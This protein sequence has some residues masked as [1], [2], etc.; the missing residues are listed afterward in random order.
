M[1][2]QPPPA[3]ER[4]QRQE[5]VIRLHGY[6]ILMDVGVRPHTHVYKVRAKLHDD[7]PVYMDDEEPCYAL[8]C[9]DMTEH[10]LQTEGKQ[11]A[12]RET[13]ALL[14][15]QH[16]NVARYHKAFLSEGRLCYM[17]EFAECGTLHHLIYTMKERG[18]RLS[19][20]LVWHLFIQICHGLKRLHDCSIIH[21][22][23]K[24]RNLLLF[25]ETL[26]SHPQFKY[27]CKLTDL[28]IPELQRHL[29]L[30]SLS[31]STLRYLAPE[32]LGKQ[33]QDE[34]VDVWALGCILYEMTT[35][36][37]AFSSTSA[38][39]RGEFAPLPESLSPELAGLLPRLLHPDPQQRPSLAQLLGMP[40]VRHRLAE[41]PSPAALDSLGDDRAFPGGASSRSRGS[42]SGG[43][44]GGSA[45][46]SASG[47]EGSAGGGEASSAD[48]SRPSMAPGALVARG[49][50]VWAKH[51]SDGLWHRGLV[52]SA[53]DADC[54]LVQFTERNCVDI[55]WCDGLRPYGP[56][57]VDERGGAE[58]SGSGAGVIL[59]F[60]KD[61]MQNCNY[62]GASSA[63]REQQTALERK[64]SVRWSETLSSHGGSEAQRAAGIDEYRKANPA[65]ST[66][67]M[68]STNASSR[69]V[70]ATPPPLGPLASPRARTPN[71]AHPPPHP[72]CKPRSPP[73]AL[74]LAVVAHRERGG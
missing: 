68:T 19:E 9:I 14:K 13:Q 16:T 15:L 33:P 53:I 22:A 74:R 5:P 12:V 43:G 73:R 26:Y 7:V 10:N 49:T 58:G 21:R 39:Q 23:L 61:D 40:A 36:S 47:G 29:R 34:K 70:G 18:Q 72:T 65:P 4:P 31:G 1:E 64:R 8:K 71:P 55:A 45:S 66:K 38:I 50:L 62:G 6:D 54:Y 51:G 67:D 59:G 37:H 48:V 69:E 32:V 60:G 57:A 11:R 25:P 17:T 24:A 30:S 27:R 46:A 35:F 28:G 63:A 56:P 44:G 52:Q 41:W 42:G 20:D 3:D 2:G